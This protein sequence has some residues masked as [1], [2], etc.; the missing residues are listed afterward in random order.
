MGDMYYGELPLSP[1]PLLSQE[2]EEQKE[3][4]ERFL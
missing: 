2:L 4:E 1:F 3:E